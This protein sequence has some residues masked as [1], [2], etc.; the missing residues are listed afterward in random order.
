MAITPEALRDYQAKLSQLSFDCTNQRKVCP[1]RNQFIDFD[2][3]KEIRNSSKLPLSPDM[4]FIAKEQ[5]EIWFVEFKSSTKENL[6]RGREKYKIKRKILDG[7]I[8]F[9]EIFQNYYDFQK[10]YFVVYNR[11]ESYEDQVL[12]EVSERDIAFDLEELQGKFLDGVITD[13]CESFINHWRDRFQI[14]F[15]RD[16]SE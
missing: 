12:V 7:L 15:E 5:K 13:S 16:F 4:L 14:N 9:Y 8:L 6:E 3:L 1:Y 2:K 10:Y 11:E